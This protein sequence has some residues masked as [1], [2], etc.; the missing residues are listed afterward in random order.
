MILTKALKILSFFYFCPPQLSACTMSSAAA[1]AETHSYH[2]AYVSST[3]SSVLFNNP[4]Y[5]L[6]PDNIHHPTLPL[7]LTQIWPR[8]PWVAQDSQLLMM[9][10][11]LST[12]SGMATIPHLLMQSPA[13]TKVQC[14]YNFYLII[15]VH[16]FLKLNIPWI[17]IPIPFPLFQNC[18]KD[19]SPKSDIAELS[20]LPLPL[21]S[22]HP[23]H[24]CLLGFISSKLSIQT[25]KTPHPYQP[26]QKPPFQLFLTPACSWNNTTSWNHLSGRAS[27]VATSLSTISYEGVSRCAPRGPL[28]FLLVTLILPH[29]GNKHEKQRIL[30]GTPQMIEIA[31]GKALWVWLLSGPINDHQM[32]SGISLLNLFNS[33]S[34]CHL[35]SERSSWNCGLFSLFTIN[36]VESEYWHVVIWPSQTAS[37]HISCIQQEEFKK[38]DSEFL[39]WNFSANFTTSLRLMQLYWGTPQCGHYRQE[40]KLLRRITRVW[41]I[42]P[43]EDIHN[44]EF[45][46]SA[47]NYPRSLPYKTPEIS[48]LFKIKQLQTFKEQ[49]K[50]PCHHGTDRSL[51]IVQI[52]RQYDNRAAL[53][54]QDGKGSQF[55]QHSLTTLTRSNQD[56]RSTPFDGS[57]IPEQLNI[58]RTQKKQPTD[59]NNPP[60]TPSEI[61]IYLSLL[62]S[63]ITNLSSFT[64]Y[65]PDQ[66]ISTNILLSQQIC[67]SYNY[68]T[69]RVPFFPFPFLSTTTTPQ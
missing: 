66:I 63:S 7:F 44:K 18:P 13:T 35:S 49:A 62:Y 60:L 4:C 21:P 58:P 15:F 41:E 26:K 23:M 12:I 31:M 34:S 14:T 54:Q 25:F 28:R 36:K 55:S 46:S 33:V 56:D 45:R 43:A 47:Q 10:L 17:F 59:I 38:I 39:F 6:G 1:T 9:S 11:P 27:N 50:F 37:S 19:S 64:R 67:H 3:P 8:A 42:P 2:L 40:I 57:T 65:P 24:S 68:E 53:A 30:R 32:K 5:H 51:E 16:F 52:P 29:L 22:L 20:L 61:S 48:T 69:L